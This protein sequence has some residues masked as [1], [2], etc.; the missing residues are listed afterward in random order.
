[1]RASPREGYKPPNIDARVLTG[2]QA[3]FWID[4]QTFQWVKVTGEVLRPVSL[5]GLLARVEPGTSFEME[6]IPV[7][8]GIWQPKHIAIR[9]NSEVLFFFRHHWYQEETFFNYCKINSTAA[10][11]E[12]CSRCDQS[13]I[14][15]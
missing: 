4:T 12:K 6:N 15:Q 5:A 14:N 13:G 1:L 10:E 3:E 11:D 2:M 7:G 9:S 8:D